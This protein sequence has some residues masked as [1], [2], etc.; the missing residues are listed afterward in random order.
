MSTRKRFNELSA[1]GNSRFRQR[2]DGIV[3]AASG[4][5]FQLRVAERAHPY[6][7]LGATWHDNDVAVGDQG[8]V[9][10][11]Q[12]SRRLPQLVSRRN[13]PNSAFFP[14]SSPAPLNGYIVPWHRVGAG[15]PGRFYRAGWD[16]PAEVDSSISLVQASGLT[17][18]GSIVRA[19]S[20]G[21]LWLVD[22]T[23][24]RSRDLADL[25]AAPTEYEQEAEIIAM[26]LD[27]VLERPY[28]WTF[29]GESTPSTDCERG[30]ADALALFEPGGGFAYA[31]PGTQGVNDCVSVAGYNALDLI[32]GFLADEYA[33]NPAESSE[34]Q[35]CYIDAFTLYYKTEYDA[36]YD[37]SGCVVPE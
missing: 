13:R 31:D 12:G 29:D 35:A 6:S 17:E 8:S 36:A 37:G 21:L 10:F 23:T 11:I 14:A 30:A 9:C 16:D 20:S 1:V 15:A 4:G 7:G 32:A 25:G 19:D 27:N 2:E 22:G 33:P 3:E 34:Y 5:S 24:L 18:T 28:I 26:G